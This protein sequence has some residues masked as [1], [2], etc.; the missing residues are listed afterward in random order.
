MRRPCIYKSS[1]LRF[2]R[3][4]RKGYAAFISIQRAVT[5]G[6]LKSS[7]TERFQKK[8][9]SH[10]NIIG[11]IMGNNQEY[12][13]M[14]SDGMG[15]SEEELSMDAISLVALRAVMA[16]QSSLNSAYISTVYIL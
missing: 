11:S 16:G 10:H 8:N 2:K 15:Y 12:D 13:E 3:W 9:I 14:A 6:Q 1:A 5:I 7:L 4:S